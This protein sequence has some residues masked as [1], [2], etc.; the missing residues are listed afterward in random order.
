M[1]T[2]EEL[3]AI[4]YT[5]KR[6]ERAQAHLDYLHEKATCIPSPSGSYGDKVQHSPSNRGNIYI[7]A[8]VDLE[9]EIK[10][11][12]AELES[13]KVQAELWIATVKDKT[14]RK[15][16]TYRYIDCMTWDDV[17]DLVGYTVRHTHRLA[18]DAVEKMSYHVL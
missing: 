3:Q 14:T 10:L 7:E 12:E 18:N 15:I 5:A 17:A 1:I 6:I 9:S 13:M 4:P 2:R 16:L 8:A 11:L